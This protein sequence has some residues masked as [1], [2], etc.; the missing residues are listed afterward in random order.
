MSHPKGG[1]CLI[2]V[3]ILVGVLTQAAWADGG[4]PSGVE[5]PV[6][7]EELDWSI[8][9]LAPVKMAL[10]A[11]DTDAAKVALLEYYR[12]RDDVVPPDPREGYDTSIADGILEGRYT[13]R[14]QQVRL[15]ADPE[16][17]Q[18]YVV[19]KGVPWPVFD[20]ELGRHTFIIWLTRAYHNTG[21]ER[22]ADYLVRMMDSYIAACP[23]EDGRAMER[24]NNMD[25][26]AAR[27]IGGQEALEQQGHPAMQWTLMSAMRKT[28]QWPRVVQMCAHSEAFTPDFLHRFLTSLIE[29]QR[30]LVDAMETVTRG[31]HGTRSA[32]TALEVTAK[33]PEFRQ[34]DEWAQRAMADLMARYNYKG[35][36]PLAFIYPDGATEEISPEVGRGDYGTL[37]LAMRW[38]EM[39][40]IPIPE[41]LLDVQER[42]I[43]YFAWITWPSE[44][45]ARAQRNRSG[46][47]LPGREDIDWIQS[48]GTEGTPPEI[49]SWPLHSGDESYAGTYFMRSDWTPEAVALRVR[50]GPRQYKYSM[51]GLGDVGDVGVWGYGMHLIPHMSY[52]PASGEFAEYGDRSHR[53]D[54]MSEN[55]IAVDGVGQS[56]YGRDVYIDEPLDNPWVTSD[57][58][59]YVRG[60]YTFDP[61]QV[62]ATHTRRVLFVKPDYFVVI[63]RVD[64]EGAH[65]YRMKYQLNHELAAAVDGTRVVGSADDRARIV[66]QPSR[67]DLDLT[68]VKGQTEPRHEGWQLLSETDAREAPALVYTWREQAPTRTETVLWPVPLGEDAD[69]K[70]A[71]E[72][73]GETVALTITFGE[74]R[75]VV[76]ID[77]GDA[78]R[79][80]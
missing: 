55:T 9:G 63:D 39:L 54:G 12:S 28:Q 2:V 30:Y 56:A 57:Q 34:R 5:P 35:T 24:I 19:P 41:Q 47:N 70:V 58:Y 29:H 62:E 65:D 15:P 6:L 27:Q 10:D 53:G 23:V 20:H 13:W 22:Y 74:R 80:R 78:L 11:G 32:A 69:L 21:E 49:A 37:L 59:D 1:R 52:H 46:P 18:W 71:R 4:I 45:P 60:G 26:L 50:F 17:I 64:A 43:Q 79:L 42:M 38:I 7:W 14:G 61:E 72:A 48:G 68:I 51:R 36:G 40:E 77:G 66:V 73:D 8:E 67:E 31:N 75:D 3:T 16:Q 25:G 44:L 33:M 76:E